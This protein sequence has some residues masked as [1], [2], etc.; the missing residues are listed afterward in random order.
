MNGVVIGNVSY[1][2]IRA[3]G[4]PYIATPWRWGYGCHL[5]VG[6]LENK[7]M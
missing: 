3:F 5:V 4:V 2:V 6:I 1:V 7:C